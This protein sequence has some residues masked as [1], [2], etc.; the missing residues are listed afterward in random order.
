[1]KKANIEGSAETACL[2]AGCPQL[3]RKRQKWCQELHLLGDSG[4][5]G[6]GS[7]LQVLSPQAVPLA[8]S[9]PVQGLL[10]RAESKGTVLTHSLAWEQLGEG[11]ERC[12]W[13]PWVD[14][15]R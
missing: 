4:L 2:W 12:R 7:Q 11:S 10:L 15:W 3:A 9:E 13:N 5:V 6:S 8:I 14:L 1:M